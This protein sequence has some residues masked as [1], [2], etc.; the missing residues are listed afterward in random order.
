[1][2]IGVIGAGFAGL[3]AAKTL[4]QFG[5]DVVVCEKAPDVGGVWS[6]TRRYPGIATQN[7]KRTYAY[8][9]FPMPR[10][11]PEWPSGIQV[12]T[13]LAGYARTFGLEPALHLGTEVTRADL[14]P[15]GVWTLR[16]A[17]GDEH[18]AE[19]LVVANGALSDPYLPDWPGR[20]EFE[21]AGGQVRH[22]S[23]FHDREIASGRDVVVVGYGKSACDAA[24]AAGE[25]AASTTVVAR[26]LL[27]KVPKRLGDVL[28]Y[29]Y[30]LLTRLGEAL[31][32]YLDPDRVQRL[33]HGP[34]PVADAMV[35]SVQAV[36]TRQ[37]GLRRLGLLPEG[38]LQD[39]ARSTISLATDG[40]HAQVAAGRIA[41][42]RD[43]RVVRLLRDPAGRPAV[44]LASGAVLPAGLLVCGTGFH[45]RVPFFAP[46][47]RRELTDSAGDFQLYRQIL[48]LTVPN[49][50]FCGYNSSFFSPLSAEIAA[51]WIAA[52]LARD[53]PLPSLEERRA[54]VRRRL[55]WMNRR[56]HGKHAHGTNVVPFSM[57]NID[58]M[59]S[60]LALDVPRT[61]RLRQWLLPVDPS[62]YAPVAEQLRRRHGF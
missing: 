20:E 54:D 2:R 55:V 16:T 28:N 49:L 41:V 3:A 13:Y 10:S 1:M 7:D 34:V 9:D 42:R 39:I 30:L 62:A 4:R 15:A 36:I 5:H 26:E 52:L 22:S 31:F 60:D 27:W 8:S 61:T 46:E 37:L 24:A 21:A 57:H 33:L 17:S 45:Q 40:F 25:V 44:E 58:E 51:L 48:P 38:P 11:Y 14:D 50:A 43:E 53:L 19:F 18:V 59:L 6:R 12:Q 32:P 35:G 23:E 56:T 29:K 47:V